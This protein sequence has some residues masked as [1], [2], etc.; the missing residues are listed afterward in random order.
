MPCVPTG[1]EAKSKDTKCPLISIP[2]FKK[3]FSQVIIDCVG[4]LLKTKSGNQYLLTIMYTSTCFPKAVL[5]QSI[6]VTTINQVL[7]FSGIAKVREV[8]LRV[9]FHVRADAVDHVSVRHCT[10]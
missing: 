8:G 9:R 5:F 1:G 7:H 3:S 2:A 10:M 6:K 4:P